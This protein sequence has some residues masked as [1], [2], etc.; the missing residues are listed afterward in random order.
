ME[1]YTLIKIVE[2]IELQADSSNDIRVHY[3]APKIEILET[4]QYQ[5][6]IDETLLKIAAESSILKQFKI[7]ADEIRRKFKTT[8][9]THNKL[10]AWAKETSP[11][12]PGHLKSS[13]KIEPQRL[14][15]LINERIKELSGKYMILP[16]KVTEL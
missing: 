16:C 6:V 14:Y 2:E 15:S 9:V 1:G 12:L 5:E 11:Q 10:E 13:Y 4:N 3:R 8:K 7:E